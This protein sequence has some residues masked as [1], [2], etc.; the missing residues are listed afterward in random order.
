MKIKPIYAAIFSVMAASIVQAAPNGGSNAGGKPFVQLENQIIEVQNYT[1][2]T[3]EQQIQELTT[4][5]INTDTELADRV[6]TLESDFQALDTRV[7][8]LE[9]QMSLTQDRIAVTEQNIDSLTNKASNLE[10]QI[11]ELLTKALQQGTDI[12]TLQQQLATI[13]QQIETI[14]AQTG[15]HTEEIETLKQQA[16]TLQTE[17]ET[18]AAG[19]TSLQSELTTTT[20]LIEGLKSE[21]LNMKGQLANMQIY[22]AGKQDVINKRC[23][24]GQALVEVSANGSI[25]CETIGSTGIVSGTVSFYEWQEAWQ[26]ITLQCPP[27]RIATGAGH[28]SFFSKPSVHFSQPEGENKWIFSSMMD[29]RVGYYLRCI[30]LQ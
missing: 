3:I 4:N 25:A 16:S 29:D 24:D 30:K 8:S 12:L 15:D 2:Q 20:L 11:D 1:T 21:L 22:L 26:P 10:T 19:I 23:P 9:T 14:L 7:T 5:V 18:N 27:G 6:S 28:A 13:N 17:I